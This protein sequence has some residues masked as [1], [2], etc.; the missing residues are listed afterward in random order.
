MMDMKDA[1]KSRERLA[2]L[3]E[4]MPGVKEIVEV[5][6]SGLFEVPVKGEQSYLKNFETIFG[7][8]TR[9]GVDVE[10][11]ALLIPEPDSRHDENAVRVFINGLLV[12]Y[13]E[14]PSGKKL[15]DSLK[16]TKRWGVVVQVQAN[17]RGGWYRGESDKGEFGVWL[18]FPSL[19]PQ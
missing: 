7:K 16:R 4:K 13:L 18:D 14:R 9:D 1:K 10:C 2:A 11:T 17:V 8:R 15:C 12:G 6:Q 5:R 19:L 3:I